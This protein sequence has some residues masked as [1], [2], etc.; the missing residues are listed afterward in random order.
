MTEKIYACN[1]MNF[2]SNINEVIRAAVNSLFIFFFTKR[3]CTHKKQQKVQK[4][5]Q[6]KVQNANKQTKIKMRSN[7]F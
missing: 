6:A 1:K 2:V 3:F 5:N 7:N 4:R